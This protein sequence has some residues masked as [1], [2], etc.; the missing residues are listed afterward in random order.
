MKNK[1]KY[2]DLAA[3]I[4][5]GILF[6]NII[7]LI[8]FE[9]TIIGYHINYSIFI[10]WLPILIGFIIIPKYL[11]KIT[12]KDIF[13]ETKTYSNFFKKIFFLLAL[14]LINI[15]TSYIT[16]GFT[17]NV[18][19]NISNKIISEQNK[20]ETYQIK[21][22]NFQRTTGKGGGN[23]INFDFKN[24]SEHLKIRYN[25]IEP[26]LNVNSDECILKLDVKK[27]VWNHYVLQNWEI[28]KK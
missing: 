21:I 15:V 13:E 18:T 25:S 27:G 19:W 10:F 11:F 8:C 17:A 6:A 4:V 5:Y 14:V 3:I 16:F 12:L 26:Y 7:Y 28:I 20:L 23:Y 9:F 2:N 24:K 1:S 22:K